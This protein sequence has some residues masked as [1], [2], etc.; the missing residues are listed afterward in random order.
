M[1]VGKVN[2]SGHLPGGNF[3][4]DLNLA[5]FDAG[6]AS[7]TQSRALYRIDDLS[8]GNVADS[9]AGSEISCSIEVFIGPDVRRVERARRWLGRSIRKAPRH[10]KGAT[11]DIIDGAVNDCCV[12]NVI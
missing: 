7:G 4:P 10:V 12:S 5:I 9:R 3:G 2:W 11:S 8:S 1:K 6:A